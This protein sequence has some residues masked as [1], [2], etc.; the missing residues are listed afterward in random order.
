MKF[1]S[2]SSIAEYRY[3]STV[4]ESRCISSINRTSPLSR[5]DSIPT[6][7]IGFSSAG[8]AVC[9]IRDCIS[10]AMIWASVV[11]PRPGGPCNKMCSTGSFLFSA[12]VSAICRLST[13]SF[14]P[15]YSESDRGR[16]FQANRSLSARSSTGSTTWSS[17]LIDGSRLISLPLQSEYLAN[18]FFNV[19]DCRADT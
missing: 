13:T 15:M 6:I 4:R 10:L 17:P 14:C 7:S 8:P 9:V 3:S 11:L 16:R 1:T 19:F 5:L 18:E 12:A 2:K